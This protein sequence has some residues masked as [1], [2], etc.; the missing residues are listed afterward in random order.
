MAFFSRSRKGGRRRED[1]GVRSV[2]F[3]LT[4]LEFVQASDELGLL[5]IG[6]HWLAPCDRELDAIVLTVRRDSESLEIE[7]LPDMKA[8][9]PFA[10]PAGEEWRGAF[11]MAVEVAEDPRCELALVAGAD[12]RV[13]L[14]RPGEPVGDEPEAEA[15]PASPIVAELMAKLEEVAHL[16]A[17]S[18]AELP[19]EAEAP[20]EL[21][22][23]PARE[24]D[25]EPEAE[26]RRVDPELDPEPRTGDPEPRRADPELDPVDPELEALRAEVEV[27]RMRLEEAIREL[28]AERDRSR[29]FETELRGR[30]SVESDLRNAIATQEAELA[31]AAAQA[32]QRARQA[33]RRRD[34]TT[35]PEDR[36][37]PERNGSRGADDDFL[38]RLER[39][40][41]ASETV[42]G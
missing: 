29:A 4:T 30:A 12:A 23:Q 28:A 37:R 38:A 39:A 11:T 6:G 22:V 13:V 27:L 9:S 8:A 2:S 1:D 15:E 41:R 24:D 25:P 19:P 34:L 10:S 16:D 5:R 35:R 17:Q 14:P 20:A 26:S 32:A 3:E 40:R 21:D 42:A 33:E 36:E 18:E 31:S 7:P